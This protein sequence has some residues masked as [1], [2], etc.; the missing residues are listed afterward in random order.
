MTD[1]TDLFRHCLHG[2]E[3]QLHWGTDPRALEQAAQALARIEPGSVLVEQL[4]L[5]AS[6]LRAARRELLRRKSMHPAVRP[7]ERLFAG[8]M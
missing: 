8:R 6:E 1:D 4:A 2:A 5:R 7:Q 3:E